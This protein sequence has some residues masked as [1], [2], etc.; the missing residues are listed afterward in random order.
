MEREISCLQMKLEKC[1]IENKDLENA[2]QELEGCKTELEG[3]LE[4]ANQGRYEGKSPRT[5]ASPLTPSR[6]MPILHHEQSEQYGQNASIRYTI[7]AK[8]E[9]THSIMRSNTTP[10]AVQQKNYIISPKN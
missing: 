6:R 8:T 1:L 9:S 7:P 5:P 4:E 10:L 3:K 2:V